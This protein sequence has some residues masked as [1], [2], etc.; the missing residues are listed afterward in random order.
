VQLDALYFA[1]QRDGTGWDAVT[2][3]RNFTVYVPAD[4][5][6]ATLELVIVL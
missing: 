4:L 3:A 6:G 1:I 2:R 5:A